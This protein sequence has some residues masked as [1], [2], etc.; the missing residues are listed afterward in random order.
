MLTSVVNAFKHKKCVSLRNQKCTTQPTLINLHPNDYIK[1][2]GHYPFT[3]NLDR[4]AKS[5]NNLNDLSNKICVPDKTGNLNL[6]VFNMIT[7]INKLETLTKHIS[8]ECKYNV[9]VGMTIKSWYACKHLKE[10]QKMKNIWNL[11]TFSCKNGI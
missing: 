8:C 6:S 7:G 3:V 9:D 10:H 11:V 2:L 1:G 4:C 5:C